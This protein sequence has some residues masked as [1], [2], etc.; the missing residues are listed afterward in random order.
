MIRLAAVLFLASALPA[1]AQ[2]VITDC[3]PWQPA[4]CE[5]TTIAQAP[6]PL[7]TC[8]LAPNVSGWL[9]QHGLHACVV[10]PAPAVHT[11]APARNPNCPQSTLPWCP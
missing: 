6:K 11:Q 8:G 10:Q 3:L 7:A 4:S 2:R 5:A 1:S 9:K